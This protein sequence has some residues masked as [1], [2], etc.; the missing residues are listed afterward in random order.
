MSTTYT[1]D[2]TFREIKTAYQ[3]HFSI[4]EKVSFEGTTFRISATAQ[5]YH[6]VFSSNDYPVYTHPI[7]MEDVYLIEGNISRHLSEDGDLTSYTEAKAILD[8]IMGPSVCID[9]HERSL[10]VIRGCFHQEM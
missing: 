8:K 10:Y 5:Q 2:T 7:E 9:L 1:L 3:V 6:H 4:H